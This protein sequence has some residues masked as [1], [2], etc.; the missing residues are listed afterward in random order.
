MHVIGKMLPECFIPS[1]P[2]IQPYAIIG[3]I[4][5]DVIQDS[6]AVGQTVLGFC[7]LMVRMTAPSARRNLEGG[8]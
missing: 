1:T 6:A 5:F 7:D 2:L 8:G 4:D 3:G